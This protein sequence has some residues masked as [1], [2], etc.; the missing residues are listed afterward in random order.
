ML[1]V[2]GAAGMFFAEHYRQRNMKNAVIKDLARLENEISQL[3]LQLQQLQNQ[4]HIERLISVLQQFQVKVTHVYCRR[5]RPKRP[6][7]SHARKAN[8]IVST[9]TDDY[10]SAANLDSSDLEF[11]DLSDEESKNEPDSLQVVRAEL[12]FSCCQHLNP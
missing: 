9:T 11:Y 12:L 5:I 3:K 4:A 7:K 6:N 1:G 8:S 10:L 2:I